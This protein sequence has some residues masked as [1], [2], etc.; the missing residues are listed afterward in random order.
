MEGYEYDRTKTNSHVFI[1]VLDIDGDGRQEALIAIQWHDAGKLHVLRPAAGRV[2]LVDTGAVV[3]QERII[4]EWVLDIDGDGELELVFSGSENGVGYYRK[5][6][7][8]P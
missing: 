2:A 5:L 4:E 8:Q 1:Q 3:P 6:R 7:R